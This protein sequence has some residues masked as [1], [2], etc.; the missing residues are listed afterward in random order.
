MKFHIVQV[1]EKVQDISRKYSVSLEEIVK[2]N[3]HINHI[4]NVV[5]GMKIRLPILSDEVSDELKDN[6]L[7]IEKYYPKIDDFKDV[8]VSKKNSEDD[9]YEVEDIE[10]IPINEHVEMDQNTQNMQ[11]IYPFQQQPQYYVNQYNPQQPVNPQYYQPQYNPQQQSYQTPYYQQQQPI[12]PQYYQ[13][14]ALNPQYYQ[15]QYN[16]QMIY[17]N[18]NQKSQYNP[19]HQVPL[20]PRDKPTVNEKDYNIEADLTLPYLKDTRPKIDPKFFEQPAFCDPILLEGLNKKKMEN[21]KQPNS[22][23]FLNPLFNPPYPCSKPIDEI[24]HCF[25]KPLINNTKEEFGFDEEVKEIKYDLRDF[26]KKHTKIKKKKDTL[27]LL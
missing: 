25:N 14:Q 10:E 16:Q 6:F 13:Q 3:R 20:D 4:D 26:I 2:L 12:N 17:P 15:N 11:N 9:I 7:D 18:Y 8:K 24:D 1:N 22:K 21:F 5:P 27:D 23:L 19:Y